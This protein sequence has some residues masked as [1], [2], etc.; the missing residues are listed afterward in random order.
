[1]LFQQRYN[2]VKFNMYSINYIIFDLFMCNMTQI[3]VIFFV[4]KFFY[5]I[6]FYC[7]GLIL[8]CQLKYVCR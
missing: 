6:C 3:Y 1:M 2:F 8:Y 5:Y 4:C 7:I